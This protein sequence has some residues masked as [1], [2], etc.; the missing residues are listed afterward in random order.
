MSKWPKEWVQDVRDGRAKGRQ[1]HDRS[2]YVYEH[3]LLEELSRAGALKDPPK[4]REFWLEEGEGN[5]VHHS[6]LYSK[7]EAEER[8]NMFRRKVIHVREVIDDG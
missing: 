2:G 3:H 8:K 1:G 7:D 6:V 5:Y 4:P